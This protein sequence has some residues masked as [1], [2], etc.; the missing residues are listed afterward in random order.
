M[1]QSQHG[2]ER[3]PR[4]F[5]S[6]ANTASQAA[7]RAS[8]FVL[9]CAAIVIWAVTG[10]LFRFSDTWQLVINT[11]TTIVTF[12]MVFLIQNSQNRDSAAIQVKLDELIRTGT[13]QNSF[14]GIEHLSADELEDL[15]ARCEARA[16]VV[17]A[18]RG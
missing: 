6:I 2:P 12:L 5:A 7:G 1:R 10:P 13:A 18:P 4:F 15:R 9:A 8:T 3:H 17:A 14:V 16:K 11:G